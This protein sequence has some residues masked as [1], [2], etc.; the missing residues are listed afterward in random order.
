MG[1]CALLF[2][3]FK[4]LQDLQEDEVKGPSSEDKPPYSYSQLIVQVCWLTFCI[5]LDTKY[6]FLLILS[7]ATT[8][9]LPYFICYRSR[10]RHTYRVWIIFWTFLQIEP[11]NSSNH[12][13]WG[14]I[15]K[16]ESITVYILLQFIYSYF[17][18]FKVK[19]LKVKSFV[20]LCSHNA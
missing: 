8:L 17:K 16:V 14:N 3:A 18:L 11:C 12:M 7:H 9:T 4:L 19:A 20:Y 15:K 6:S 13:W 5:F 1:T 10:S 2:V